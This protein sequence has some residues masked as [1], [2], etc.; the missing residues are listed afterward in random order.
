MTA[1][2]ALLIKFS[3]L[4]R[5]YFFRYLYKMN[6]KVTCWEVKGQVGFHPT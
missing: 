6:M 5:E 2:P 3:F 1:V 4:Y